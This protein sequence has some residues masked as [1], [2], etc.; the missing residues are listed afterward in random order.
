[1][2]K[3]QP[4]NIQIATFNQSYIFVA[5]IVPPE[6]FNV[7]HGVDDSTLEHLPHSRDPLVLCVRPHCIT[8]TQNLVEYKHKVF[9]GSI[10]FK[11]RMDLIERLKSMFTVSQD[12][13]L[14][15]TNM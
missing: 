9:I 1:L 8:T 12:H 11:L 10:Y 15:I 4:K 5:A 6:L 7:D 14:E 13:Q 2:T 3:T